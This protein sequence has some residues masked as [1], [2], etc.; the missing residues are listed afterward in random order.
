MKQQQAIDIMKAGY[1][2]F[3]TG[4]A[5]SGKTHALNIFIEYLRQNKYNVGVTASTGIAGTH[6]NGVTIHSWSGI[7]IRN[8]LSDY[9][10]DLLMQK[11]VLHKRYNNADV[12]IIDEVSMLH[13]Y[14]LEMV[15]YLA[16]AFRQNLQPFGGLQVV[17]CGDLFQLPPVSR[18]GQ[19]KLI[20]D[21]PI[22][23]EMNLKVCYLHEQFRQE[24][25]DELLDVLQEIRA[26]TIS[27]QSESVLATRFNAEINTTV[28]PTKLFTH[29]ADVDRINNQELDLLDAEKRTFKMTST[30]NKKLVASLIKLSPAVEVLHLKLGAQV[31]F[32]KNDF[33]HKFVNGTRGVVVDFESTGS[34]V[35]ETLEGRR[36]KVTPIEWVIEDNGKT[37]AKLMQL[38]LRLAWAITV[39]KS[40]G[41]SLDTAEIDLSGAFEPGMGYVALSR[42]RSLEGLVLR[43]MN[44]VALQ[45]HPRIYDFDQKIQE[46]STI[47]VADLKKLLANPL[48]DAETLKKKKSKKLHN[49]EKT[50]GFLQE[51]MSVQAI[52]KE[53]KFAPTTIIGHIE[54]LVEEGREIDFDIILPETDANDEIRDAFD[55]IGTEFLKPVYEHF[56]GRYP[57]SYI[58][59]V[60]AKYFL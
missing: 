34:P 28:K 36:I 17:L 39:H 31:M 27:K 52:A 9:D 10:I 46:Q 59:L 29:N 56:E 45:V 51:G 20:M 42:V 53:L 8:Q 6:L 15:N 4:A 5:G 3:L 1:N 14:Q 25:K 33:E 43:G 22:W 19:I 26:N 54:Q 49:R 7:G 41:M 18:D 30:G 48:R 16:Q 24:G 44:D 23:Q 38:P 47:V 60:R 21:A 40:Q 57:Y 35:V 12:L 32:V 55:E 13:A 37:L 50:F 58:R 2:V 11:E